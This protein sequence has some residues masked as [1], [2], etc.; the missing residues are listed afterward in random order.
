MR[1]RPPRKPLERRTPKQ[2]AKVGQEARKDSG[3]KYNNGDKNAHEYFDQYDSIKG[4]LDMHIGLD[5]ILIEFGRCDIFSEFGR[6]EIGSEKIFSQGEIGR[7]GGRSSSQFERVR[8][9]AA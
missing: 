4:G 5:N 6:A 1:A 7:K 2:S 9:V 8:A 3:N